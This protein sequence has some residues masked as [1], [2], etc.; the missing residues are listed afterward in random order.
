MYRFFFHICSATVFLMFVSID[1]LLMFKILVFSWT[2]KK[3]NNIWPILLPLAGKFGSH[4]HNHTPVHQRCNNVCLHK[5]CRQQ[6]RGSW[7]SWRRLSYK[8]CKENQPNQYLFIIAVICCIFSRKSFLAFFISNHTEFHEWNK[9]LRPWNRDLYYE[10]LLKILV[11][12][13]K[14]SV[15]HFAV[16]PYVK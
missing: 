6:G 16:R 4:W 15:E 10:L 5:W 3:K 11:M 1:Q 9:I 7:C 13:W 14:E 12:P 2:Q 8:H